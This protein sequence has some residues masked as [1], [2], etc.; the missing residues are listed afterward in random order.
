MYR[1]AGV[2]VWEQLLLARDRVDPAV[3]PE[4]RHH[5]QRQ[6]RPWQVGDSYLP[7]PDYVT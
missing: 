6:E 7:P 1:D 5:A 3:G 2:P 4:G